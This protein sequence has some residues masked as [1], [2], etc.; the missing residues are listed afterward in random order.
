M[1]LAKSS[2]ALNSITLR[3]HYRSRHEGL[4]AFSNAKFYDGRLIETSPSAEQDGDDVGVRFFYVRGTYRR[5]T[6]RTTR[7]KLRL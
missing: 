3:W 7:S 4:I 2:A 1:D 5:G 6:S